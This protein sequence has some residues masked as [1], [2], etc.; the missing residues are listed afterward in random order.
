MKITPRTYGGRRA[1]RG[2]IVLKRDRFKAWSPP[3]TRYHE[4]YASNE[5]EPSDETTSTKNTEP[6]GGLPVEENLKLFPDFP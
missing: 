6:Q 3:L 2:S 1:S 5:D 4:I